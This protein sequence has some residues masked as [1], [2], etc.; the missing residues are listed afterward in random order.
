MTVHRIIFKD[1]RRMEEVDDESIHLVV[2]SP[3][4]PMI[5]LWDSFFRRIDPRIDRLWGRME[6]AE[7][8]KEKA[9]L[10]LQ[11]YELMHDFLMGVWR[12]V[13]RVLAEG[14]IACINIGDAARN[15]GGFFKVYPNHARIIECFERLGF[16]TPPYIFWKKPI[17]SL[18]IRGKAPS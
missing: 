5:E 18:N 15:V 9:K 1:S 16:T 14:G 6:E 10:A 13:Y 17:P 2:T 3:P 11:I 8:L 12:E 4:Y 7:G